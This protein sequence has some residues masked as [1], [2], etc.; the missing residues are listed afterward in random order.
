MVVPLFEMPN[1]TC[2]RLLLNQATAADHVRNFERV[3]HIFG[4]PVTFTIRLNER[5][6][7]HHWTEHAEREKLDDCAE[8]SII[9]YTGV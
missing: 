9:T 8:R 7:L 5:G 3:T 1:V 6:P 2:L 4:F